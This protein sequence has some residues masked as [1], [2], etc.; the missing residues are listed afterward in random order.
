M[1]FRKGAC[2]WSELLDGV[3]RMVFTKYMNAKE[4]KRDNMLDILKSLRK[5]TRPAETYC[6]KLGYEV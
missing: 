6:Q 1:E 5:I 4:R 2:A 3:N